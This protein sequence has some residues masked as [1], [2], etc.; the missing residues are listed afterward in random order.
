MSQ[1]PPRSPQEKKALSYAKDRRNAYG[2]NAKASRKAIPLRKAGENRDDRRKVNQELAGLPQ[3]DEAAAA[4][5]ESSARHEINRVGGWK[6][7][8]DLPLGEFL[9]QQRKFRARRNK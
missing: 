6:K 5:I 9:E 2:E 3:L 1:S 8:P 4:L 7:W